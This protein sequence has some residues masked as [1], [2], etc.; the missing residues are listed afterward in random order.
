MITCWVC[1]SK[2]FTCLWGVTKPYTTDKHRQRRTTPTANRSIWNGSSG[3]CVAAEN[4]SSNTT[5]LPQWCS[6]IRGPQ[7]LLG[8]LQRHRCPGSHLPGP[9]RGPANCLLSQ[10]PQQF[11]DQHS[12]TTFGEMLF[13]HGSPAPGRAIGPTLQWCSYL[14]WQTRGSKPGGDTLGS[15]F[16]PFNGE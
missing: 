11:R 12:Q 13:A 14:C 15:I 1:N 7:N 2:R 5:G 6:N 16:S 4:H 9:A 10:H 8:T 3:A